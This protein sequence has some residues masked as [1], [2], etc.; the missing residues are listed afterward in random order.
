[1]RISA[2][3]I[4]LLTLLL[5]GCAGLEPAQPPDLN[6]PDSHLFGVTRLAFNPKG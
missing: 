6:I 3:L 2:G 5:S 4:L 1:M